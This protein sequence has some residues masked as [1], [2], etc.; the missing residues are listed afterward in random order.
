MY[1]KL[2]R[3]TIFAHRGASAYAPENTLAAFHLAIQQQADAIE[4]D[5]KLSADGHVVIIHDQTVDRTTNGKGKVGSLTLE[6]LRRLDAG[7][8]Y[9]Q[10][11]RG[12]TIPTLDEVLE[13]I[14]SEIFLNI[15][16]TNYASPTDSLPEVV[17]ERIRAFNLDDRVLISSFNPIAL[18]RFHQRAPH[19]PLGLLAQVGITGAWARSPLGRWVPHQ[20]LHPAF[21]D[22]TKRLI[23]RKQ[24]HGY[25]VHVYTV[26]HPQTLTQLFQWGVDG[27]FT[28]DPPLAQRTLEAVTQS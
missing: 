6:D 3:P 9:D 13:K 14:G 7:Q 18:R 25:R 16:L 15:E 11:F 12:E 2:P 20:A 17:A 24:R 10:A 8:A 1:E 21:Q 27:V 22:A 5:A 4:F 26:N 28:D 23:A 19:I